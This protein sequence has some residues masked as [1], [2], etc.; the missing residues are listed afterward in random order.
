MPSLLPVDDQPI[1]LR[2]RSGPMLSVPYPIELND[3]G[4]AINRRESAEVFA[5]MIVGQF[6]E[7]IRQCESNPLVMNVS[8]HP[9]IFGQP[10]RVNRLRKALVHCRQH[11]QAARVWWTSPGA[12]SEHCHALPPGTLPGSP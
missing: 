6:D 4:V 3:M 2:T 1:W 7:M 8:V 5:D 12:I 9:F 11:A 10:F